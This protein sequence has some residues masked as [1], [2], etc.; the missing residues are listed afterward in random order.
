MAVGTCVSQEAAGIYPQQ[1]V[2]LDEFDRIDQAVRSGR[3]DERWF[4]LLCSLIQHHSRIA[5][6]LF[7]TF[8][9]AECDPR[10]YEALKSAQL[11]PVSYLQPDEARRVFTQPAPDFP[12]HVYSEAAILRALD[13]T[14][15][16]PYLVHLLGATVVQTY[17]RQRADLP[18]GTPPGTPL[19][20]QA[21]DA[22]IPDVV[23]S[24][25]LALRSI[26]QW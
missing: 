21:I 26:W 1:S 14:G 23:A 20:V 4:F 16:Q 15:G 24:G 9:L 13:L 17:N 12:A 10:W 7:G 18:P 25:D 6:A 3:L 19:P 22:A 5:L 8:T 2:T 11:L